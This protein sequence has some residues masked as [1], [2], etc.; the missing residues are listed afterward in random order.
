[1]NFVASGPK[2]LEGG[3]VTTRETDQQLVLR[4]Q[5]EQ[6]EAEHTGC[7][8]L[9]ADFGVFFM[10]C[11]REVQARVERWCGVRAEVTEAVR[12]LH[13]SSKGRYETAYGLT[14]AFDLQRGNTQGCSQSPTRAKMQLRMMQEDR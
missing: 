14:E 1:M 10:S 4:A 7:Y 3:Y 12:A 9:Y 8:R 2:H 5:K 11:V 13:D 6:C